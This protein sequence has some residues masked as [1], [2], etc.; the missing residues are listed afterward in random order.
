MPFGNGMTG[1]HKT[2]RRWSRVELDKLED[3]VG[4]TTF[5]QA[6]RLWNSWAAQEGIEQRS[7][8]SIAKKA[9]EQGISRN[10]W[11][12]WLLVGEVA[13]LLGKHRSTIRNWVNA[14]WIRRRGTARASA[15]CR[16]DLR[17]LARK[18]PQ[19][20]GG[21]DRGALVQLLESEDLADWV[22]ER[23]PQRWQDRYHGHRVVWLDRGLVF[24]SYVAASKAAHVNSKAIRQS[25]IEQR[26][27]CGMRFARV[28]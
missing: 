9:A 20:F 16:V 5:D 26:P 10:P 6:C 15:V 24:D 27:V 8:Q 13:Q 2:Y 17:R 28:S 21:V 18:R 3:L 25:I 14:G 19:L 1:S 7:K 11:G 22:L 12:D 23:Y 4:Q